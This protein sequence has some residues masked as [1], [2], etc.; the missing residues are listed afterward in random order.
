MAVLF[1]ITMSNTKQNYGMLVI[2]LTSTEVRTSKCSFHFR[3][4]NVRFSSGWCRVEMF[5]A[6]NIPIMPNS[7]GVERHSLFSAGLA[8]HCEANRRPHFLYG[9]HEMQDVLEGS[10]GHDPVLL[11][12]LQN[13]YFSEFDPRKG[14]LSVASDMAN[15][16][17]LV[18]ELEPYMSRVEESYVGE[19]NDKGENHG[20]GV[21]TWDNGSIYDGEWVNGVS[22]GH[23]KLT[24]DN[25]DIYVGEWKNDLQHGRGISKTANGSAYN[26]EWENGRKHGHGVFTFADGNVYEGEWKEDLKHGHGTFH[27]ANGDVFCGEYRKNMYDGRGVFTFSSGAN[28]NGK[29]FLQLHFLLHL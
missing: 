6:A 7:D 24:Y 20:H 28:Y 8:F 22:E 5:Y 23:G 18:E 16:I 29:W 12:P 1:P 25:G 9:N 13:A 3:L 14:C 21:Q 17:M 27:F 19:K 2:I 11:P 10:G 15:I 4:V 26:G